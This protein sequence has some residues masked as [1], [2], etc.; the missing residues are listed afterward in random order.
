MHKAA[1]DYHR[2]GSIAEAL[3][4]LEANPDARPIAG[5]QS[6]LG[7]MKLRLA[8]PSALVDLG[9]I[10]DLAGISS[11]GDTITIM[12]MTTHDEVATSDV[13]AA[14]CRVLCETAGY[15]GDVQVR[16]RG[17]IGG[18]VAHADPAADYPPVL[19]ALGAEIVAT[20]KTGERTIPAADFFVDIFTTA[21]APGELVTAVKVPVTSGASYQAHR[22][23]ASS[24]A[25]A[26]AA[27]VVAMSNGS[28]GDARLVVG[29]VTGKPE[30]IAA[31]GAALVGKEPSEDNIAAAASEVAGALSNPMGDVYASGEYR[32]HLATIMAKRA[33]A[34]A[35]G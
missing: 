32:V 19:V 10:P 13:L 33:L 28:V 21:L 11:D 15:I 7:V 31:A 35:A 18:S 27:A 9:Q 12:A 1:F 3:D 30:T 6:L 25:V 14:H 5:G 34:A 26:S 29:G 2:A 22:H 17:T 24:Y 4:L 23:P 16:N 20:S 8:A